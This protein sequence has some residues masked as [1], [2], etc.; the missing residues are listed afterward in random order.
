MI[1][2]IKSIQ[3][4]DPVQPSFFEVLLCYPG[5]HVLL[6]H[7]IAHV[8][9]K[10]RLRALARL[11]AHL[12][13]FLTGIEIHPQ[14]QIGR[15]LFIDHG[16]GVVIGQTS[17]IGDEVTIYHGVTLGGRGGRHDPGAK[18]HPTIQDGA[19]IGAYAQVLG[20]ITVGKNARV[21]AGSVL[22][23]DVP[24]GASVVGNPAHM[25]R[26]MKDDDGR[27]YG[28]PRHLEDPVT[29]AIKTLRQ[30]LDALFDKVEQKQKSGGKS[31]PPEKKSIH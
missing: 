15:N 31:D 26:C 20:D 12:A 30:D 18:R 16:L 9:W 7:R 13:R 1:S 6:F 8:I 11:L 10:I 29:A 21:G 5:L 22:L 24:Q 19:V 2:L 4:R 27:S 28:I 3:E 23:G 17:V 14:A 25:V